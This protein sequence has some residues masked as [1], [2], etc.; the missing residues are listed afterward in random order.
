MVLIFLGS[1]DIPDLLNT[2]PNHDTEI[3]PKV[4]F[5]QHSVSP[6]SCRRVRHLSKLSS[7]SSGVLPQT[8]ILS[9]I[10]LQPGSPSSAA[11]TLS[12]NTSVAGD[13]PKSKT[14]NLCRPSCVWK[15]DIPHDSSVRLIW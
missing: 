8:R 10:D 3:A 7:C 11:L 12:W 13:A 14:L 2:A 15:V 4:H 6:L 1:A 9:C 5:S